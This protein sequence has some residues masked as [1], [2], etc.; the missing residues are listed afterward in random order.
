LVYLL[1]P[2]G[3]VGVKA[4]RLTALHFVLLVKRFLLNL[5]LSITK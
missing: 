4:L 2:A 5:F 1:L 3:Y